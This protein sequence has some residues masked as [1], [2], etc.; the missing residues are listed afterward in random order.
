MQLSLEGPP[1]ANKPTTKRRW[2]RQIRLG[3][4]RTDYDRLRAL[5]PRFDG[6]TPPRLARHLVLLAIDFFE[7]NPAAPTA[8]GGTP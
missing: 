5:R 4:N 1:A 2:R 7:Q 8:P 3:L 6:W